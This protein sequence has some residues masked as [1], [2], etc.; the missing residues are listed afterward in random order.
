ME[1]CVSV[2]VGVCVLAVAMPPRLNRIS[3]CAADSK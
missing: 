3:Q 2:Y 1:V